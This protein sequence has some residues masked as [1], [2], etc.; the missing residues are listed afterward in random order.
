M[1]SLFKAAVTHL[2]TRTLS[3]LFSL[4]LGE[5]ESDLSEE[6]VSRREAGGNAGAGFLQRAN[7]GAVHQLRLLAV[8]VLQRHGCRQLLRVLA[9]QQARGHAR[10]AHRR[11]RQPV[12]EPGLRE[13]AG[14]P[15]LIIPAPR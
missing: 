2:H 4:N 7:D 6:D 14:E 3:T 8:V 9:Q 13:G 12:Q 11:R 5:C 15:L 1:P 10:R